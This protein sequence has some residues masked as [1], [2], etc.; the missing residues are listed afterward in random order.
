MLQIPIK[1]LE[2]LTKMAIERKI[3]IATGIATGRETVA[4]AIVI[5]TGVG[6]RDPVAL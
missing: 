2:G 6:A 4:T 5:A 3:G 1:A